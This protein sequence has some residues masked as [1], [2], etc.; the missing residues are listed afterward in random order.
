MATVEKEMADDA[1]AAGFTRELK[2]HHTERGR[3]EYFRQ[4]P[5]AR[6]Q[7][8]P[9]R[10]S[11][12]AKA[13]AETALTVAAPEAKAASAG[14]I[15]RSRA[16][17]KRGATAGGGGAASLTGQRKSRTRSRST[18]KSLSGKAHGGQLL[19]EFFIAAFVIAFTLFTKGPS[20]DI[21]QPCLT[22][23]SGCQLS[24]PYSLSSSW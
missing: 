19:A 16:G 22:L 23:S 20:M 24:Q 9:K 15:G 18:L 14:S 11:R 17:G 6:P 5:E 4:N 7:E 3:Q 12:A 2:R 8:R 13:G 1:Y 10:A 21:R